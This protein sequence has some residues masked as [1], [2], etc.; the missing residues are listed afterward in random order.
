MD[1][2]KIKKLNKRIP[3]CFGEK[4]HIFGS[5]RAQSEEARELLK[6]YWK[7]N[8]SF[9]RYVKAMETYL[10]SLKLPNDHVANQLERVRDIE[11]Y[12]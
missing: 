8:L 10:K 6:K 5:H 2:D 12:F 4:D 9:E 11:N 7:N 3:D 1:D